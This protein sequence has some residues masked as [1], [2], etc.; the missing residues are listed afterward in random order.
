MTET[1][2]ETDR[3]TVVIAKQ[4][5]DLRREAIERALRGS[6]PEPIA[7]HY[8]VV[9]SRRYPPKQAIAA[10]TGLDRAD[11]T[12]H[13]A[14]RILMR[15]G[16]A[17]GR[18]HTERGGRPDRGSVSAQAQITASAASRR[19]ELGATLARLR[20]QWVAVK[21]DELLVAAATPREVV[22][23]LA[24]YN[25]RA[26]SMYRVPEDELAVTGLAPL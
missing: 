13:Q 22:A 21:G 10:V 19:R 12:T 24:R 4:R 23:W 6:L 7:N 14:R 3:R 9:G 26:D 20:G 18:L 2:R 16:F 17:V 8:V 5:F 15:L 25:Q 1:G 11:F